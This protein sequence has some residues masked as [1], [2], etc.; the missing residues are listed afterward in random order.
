MKLLSFAL[1]LSAIL[2]SLAPVRSAPVS[3]ANATG[4]IK[5]ACVGDSITEGYN[6][7]PGESF[8]SQLSRLLG[9]KWDVKVL[10]VGGTTMQKK[11][12]NPYWNRPEYKAAL[13]MQPDVVIIE[14][15]TNDTKPNNWHADAFVND[16]QAMIESFQALPTKPH[17]YLCLPPPVFSPGGYNIPSTGPGEVI[18]LVEKLASQD[19]CDLIDFN[20]TLQP[21]AEWMPDHVHPGADGGFAMAKIAYHALTGTDYTGAPIPPPAAH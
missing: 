21:H 3:L 19:H 1:V 8:A 9:D 14:L 7:P 18:P 15:G 11:A 2:G 4:P 20:T 6:A 17:I 13:A 10:G 5:V 16:Y 12:D